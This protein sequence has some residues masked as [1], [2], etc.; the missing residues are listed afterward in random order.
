ML[1]RNIEK[2]DIREATKIWND[3]IE[4]DDSFPGAVS[5]SEEEAEKMFSAQTETVCAVDDSGKILGLYILHPN[6][7]GRCGHISNASYA[8]SRDARGKGVGRILVEDSVRRAQ[9]NGFLGLQFNAVVS[10]NTPAV[11]LYLKLGFSVIG[12]IR[13]GYRLHSG[14]FRD[15]LIFL[16]SWDI[17]ENVIPL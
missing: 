16:K 5:L 13:N 14:E 2:K 6:N 15:I 17:P 10:T 8:V 3:V 1:L 11:A 7:I 9:K 12:T 4:N